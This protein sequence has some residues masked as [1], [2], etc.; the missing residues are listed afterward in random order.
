MASGRRFTVRS[1][2]ASQS[3]VRAQMSRTG[4]TPTQVRAADAVWWTIF[5]TQNIGNSTNTPVMFFNDT[6]T[7]IAGG[8]APNGVLPAPQSMIIK[9]IS[10][11]AAGILQAGLK[12]ADYNALMTAVLQ[13]TVADKLFLQVPL[14]RVGITCTLLST[15]DTGSNPGNFAPPVFKLPIPIV[16]PSQSKFSASVTTGGVAVTGS[17]VS[18]LVLA[19]EM[20]RLV[21]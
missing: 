19:G 10:F 16:I 11:M 21:V 18:Q 13:L 7:T 14:N 8:N 17:I 4:L 20:N 15:T 12:Y 9:E 6:P 1:K 5:S 2:P 3:T